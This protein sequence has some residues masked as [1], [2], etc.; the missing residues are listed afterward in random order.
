MYNQQM[1]GAYGGAGMGMPATYA[2]PQAN[3]AAGNF[4]GAAQTQMS[5]A[6]SNAGY[7]GGYN[8]AAYSADGT[9]TGMQASGMGAGMGGGGM[10]GGQQ[11]ISPAFQQMASMTGMSPAQMQAM[12]QVCEGLVCVASCA[13]QAFMIPMFGQFCCQSQSTKYYLLKDH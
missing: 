10:G 2:M 6:P 4:A 1:G 8:A 13:P 7:G 11:A 12:Y 9:G 5:S 3:A